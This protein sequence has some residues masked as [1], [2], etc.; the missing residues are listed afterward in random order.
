MKW[1]NTR[2]LVPVN[3]SVVS[4][5]CDTENYEKKTHQILNNLVLVV[6]RTHT[7]G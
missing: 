6:V 5:G 2:Y 3:S 1:H 7:G 4:C